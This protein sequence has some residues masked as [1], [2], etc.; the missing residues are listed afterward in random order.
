RRLRPLPGG[1][2]PLGVRHPAPAGDPGASPEASGGRR[3]VTPR[4]GTRGGVGPDR[5]DRGRN[6]SPRGTG[7]P[8]R[9]PFGPAVPWT[10]F[11]VVTSIKSA[12]AA[13]YHSRGGP[14]RRGPGN[15]AA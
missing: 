2:G 12:A 6:R 7:R 9:G 5:S 4:T 10:V 8:P 3:S 11:G 13:F 1:R 14:D 15:T